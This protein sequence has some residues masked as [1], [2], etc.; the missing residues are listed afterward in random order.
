MDKVDAFY[1]RFLIVNKMYRGKKYKSVFHFELTEKLADELLDLVLRGIKKATASSYHS[2]IFD[3]EA[4]PE[5]GDMNIVTN[6]KGEPKCIIKTKN[7]L[8]TPFKEL[9]YDIVKR[10]GE[11]ESLAS[12]Q[13]GHLRFFEAEAK[14]MG[15]QFD[16]NML[17]VFEDFEVIYKE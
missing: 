8:V 3:N 17:I 15:Y 9:T 7:V 2:Y 13:E 14:I 4:L 1:E 16:E 5:V 11:D 12:W 10:E 6:F